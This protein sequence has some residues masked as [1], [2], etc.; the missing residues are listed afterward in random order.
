[1]PMIR[2]AKINRPDKYP[3]VAVVIA[4]VSSF[5]IFYF[6]HGCVVL[7]RHYLDAVGI[8]LDDHH[9]WMIK[10]LFFFQYTAQPYNDLNIDGTLFK[11]IYRDRLDLMHCTQYQGNEMLAIKD[12]R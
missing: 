1:M 5:F 10:V 3:E 4:T 11:N 2:L 9:Q 7:V 12:G 6:M 8:I